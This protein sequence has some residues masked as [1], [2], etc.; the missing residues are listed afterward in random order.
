MKPILIHLRPLDPKTGLRVDIRLGSAARGG[1]TGV[2]GLRWETAISRRPRISIDTMSPDLDGSLQ[3]MKADF[4]CNTRKIKSHIDPA[5][6]NWIGAECTIYDA[7]NMNLLTVEF[8]GLVRQPIPDLETGLLTLNLE[9]GIDKLTKPALYL[10]YDGSGGINGF[11]ELRGSPRPAGFGFCEN[12][13]LVM[14]D[15]VRNIGQVDGYGNLTAVSWLGEGLNSFGASVG[16]YASYALLQAAVD[17]QAIPAGR[18]ATCLSAGCIALGAPPAGVITLDA[19]FGTNKTGALIRRLIET[20]ATIPVGD[21]AT[22]D[23]ATLD[24]DVNREVRVYLA[25]QRDVLDLCEALAGAVNAGLLIRPDGK[26]TITRAFGG[27]VISTI[28]RNAS[29]RP[30]YTDWKTAEP[31]APVWRMKART[32][33]PGRVMTDAEINFADDLIDRGAYSNTEVYRLGHYV[34][35]GDGSQWLYINGTPAA[36]NALPVWPTTSNAYWFNRRPPTTASDL[37]YGD[38][39][40]IEALKPAQ[41]G[42]TSG[43]P[44]GTY[45]GGVLVE[46]LIADRNALLEIGD[47][48]KLTPVEKQV[49][50]REYADM[51][52]EYNELS[53]R[54]APLGITTEWAN[55]D[56][57]VSNLNIYLSALAPAW[58][59]TIATTTIIRS[60]WRSSWAAVFEK[61]AALYRK[62]SEEDA[63]RANWN[64]T[65]SRPPLLTGESATVDEFLRDPSVWAQAAGT[66]VISADGEG[67]FVGNTGVGSQIYHL[68]SNMTPIDHNAT[69]E[70]DIEVQEDGTVGVA[71][72]GAMYLGVR[73]LDANGNEIAGDGSFWR[74]FR[75]FQG[76][77]SKGIWHKFSDR[78]GRG[79]NYPFPAGA[80]KFGLLALMNYNNVG[81][82]IHRVRRMKSRRITDNGW[83]SGD[84]SIWTL[85]DGKIVNGSRTQA[86]S[87]NQTAFEKAVIK[88]PQRFSWTFSRLNTNAAIMAGL[89]EVSSPS[90]FAEG[91]VQIYHTGAASQVQI[92]EGGSYTTDYPSEPNVGTTEYALEYDGLY[93]R[94]LRNGVPMGHS[95]FVGPDKSYRAFIDVASPNCG[96]TGAKHVSTQSVAVVGGNTFD[97]AGTAWIASNGA[98]T[99]L[100]LL[101]LGTGAP[102]IVGNSA[103]KAGGAGFDAAVVNLQPFRGTAFASCE[104]GPGIQYSIPTLDEDITNFIRDGAGGSI[105]YLQYEGPS[106]VWGAYMAGVLIAT[107]TT[108]ANLVGTA[109]VVYDGLTF[110]FYVNGILLHSQ[111]TTANQTLY[112]KWLIFSNV[113]PQV[114]MQAGFATDRSWTN[115]GGTGRPEDNAT[116]GAAW[117]VNVTGRPVE[118]TDGRLPGAIDSSGYLQTG[119]RTAGG[120]PAVVNLDIL[121]N[122]AG[123]QIAK[124]PEFN[125]GSLE[126]YTIYDNSGGG[127]TSFLGGGPYVDLTAPNGSGYV[128]G[129]NYN[130][131]GTENVNPTPGWG[132]L[133][134]S[135]LPDG[136]VRRPG[137]YSRGTY[138]YYKIWAAIPAGRFIGFATN[139]FGDGGTF[140]WMTDQQG[141]GNW[142]LYIARQYIGQNGTHSSTGFLFISGGLNIAFNWYLAKYDV[143]DVTSPP[144]TFLGRGG[145]IDELGNPLFNG[146]VRNQDI[147]LIEDALGGGG[148]SRFNLR[149]N[150][151]AETAHTFEPSARLQNIDQQWVDVNGAAKPSD[152]AT[153]DLKLLT[154]GTGIILKGN[155]VTRPTG[156]G[157]WTAQAYSPD[158]YANGAYCSFSSEFNGYFMAGLNTDPTS[159]ASYAS[160]DFCFYVPADS[161]LLLIY[162]SGEGIAGNHGPITINTVMSI[163]YDNEFVRYLKDGVEVRAVYVGAGKKYHFDSSIV[164]SPG[165]F[166]IRFGPYAAAN[167]PLSFTHTTAHSSEGNT[168]FKRANGTNDW[169]GKSIS[170]EFSQGTAFVS[171]KLDG[172]NTFI[173]LHEVGNAAAS[174]PAFAYAWHRNAVGTWAIYESGSYV[175]DYGSGFDS[176]TQWLITYDGANVRYYAG[177]T[178]LRMVSSAANRIF[179]A[180]VAIFPPNSVVSGIQFGPY[181]DRTWTNI[182][183]P[184]KP[185]NNATLGASWTAN[186]TARPVELTDG[187]IADG[188]DTAG[189]IRRS[190]P[191]NIGHKQSST[192]TRALP[193][194][195][196]IVK[197]RD[198]DAY[199]FPVAWGSGQVPS[200]QAYNNGYVDATNYLDCKAL[201]VTSSGFT[202]ECKKVGPGA[203]T[204]QS[205][206]TGVSPSAPRTHEIQKAVTAEAHDDTYNYTFNVNI[207][208]QNLGGGEYNP[209]EIVVG[210]WTYDGATWQM[211]GTVQYFGQG[212]AATTTVTG[213]TSSASR[214]GMGLNDRFGL[215][216]ESTLYGGTITAFSSVTFNTTS[217]NTI[218]SATPTDFPGIPFLILGGTES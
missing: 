15:K 164:Q 69:Y 76:V 147:R 138:L 40:L 36:G 63:K 83:T 217:G 144:R 148:R 211:N 62:I 37:R 65:A 27:A 57:A 100:K 4:I 196:R 191:N 21:V 142:K 154:T 104:C 70:V 180:G 172:P 42:A 115:I 56:T 200:V 117:P 112:A 173:A 194:G 146:N 61:M 79:T 108:T 39:T 18:W 206:T 26:L 41:V 126:T 101:A 7:T 201:S 116:V 96:I 193:R 10:E 38:G 178:L 210:I 161:N 75:A 109:S 195:A 160:I 33:R 28:T 213:A 132:G 58:N 133:T 23:F 34:W 215:S 103:S 93:I 170:R 32:A 9:V 166:N 163:V 171:G 129:I 1:Y 78:I 114:G 175:A 120:F 12:I 207:T 165:F 212:D 11:A 122:A 102:V 35:A 6:L 218:T 137:Y 16:N 169:D 140:E 55:F 14:I 97:M 123:T 99:T 30:R 203:L 50:I 125:G 192:V 20:H 24:V 86:A 202:A 214:D 150:E 89:S 46:T 45:V 188:L 128:L 72:A 113:S 66:F 124:N 44:N 74:Y 190:L 168:V 135:L 77:A 25:E 80:T 64:L 157:D 67:Q 106:G 209:G 153:S 151:G 183:G 187:R 181:T 2:G 111:P 139:A 22:A 13:E 47:D 92:Y 105:A 176:N 49:V 94:P 88:G 29:S 134:I 91:V 131:A 17:S 68:P 118:L 3:S 155:S 136:G 82:V 127:K 208:N 152:Y 130:G 199:T 205:E 198:G 204:G 156:G 141:T 53:A 159:D 54:I 167:A 110:S 149:Y 85:G 216:I 51:V 197:L 52:E 19:T 121:A 48:D 177:S 179:Q 81:G 185:E 73:L 162:E 189:D 186:V 90:V 107:G 59:N 184:L 95:K 8:K 145:L 158:G 31:V 174:W 43:A 87:W 71:G 119:I 5:R 84:P 182:A 143:I 98:G 60:T